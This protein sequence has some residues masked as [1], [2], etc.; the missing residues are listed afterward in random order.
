MDVKEASVKKM[1]ALRSL[2]KGLDGKVDCLILTSSRQDD[3]EEFRHENQLAVPFAFADNTVLKTIIRSNPGIALWKNGKV[4]GNW[5]YN[6]TPSSG[7]IL[8]MIQ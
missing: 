4:L 1:D 6:D 7:E 3:V 2:T 5:H 8:K